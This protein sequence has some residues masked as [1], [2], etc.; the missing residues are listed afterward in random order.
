VRAALWRAGKLAWL[1]H[2]AQRG[3]RDHFLRSTALKFVFCCSRRWGKSWLLCVLAL[4]CALGGERRQI[5][6]AASTAKDVR[7]IIRPI[8]RELVQ[9]CPE[10][11]RPEWNSAEGAWT[12]HNGSQIHIAGV[13]NGNADSLRGTSAHLAIVDEAGFV[14]DLEYLVKSVLM[15]QLLTTDGRMI[16]SSTPATTPGHAFA[17][18]CQEA[19][20]A[21]AYARQTIYDAPHITDAKI[22]LYVA[23]SGGAQ[24]STWRR[25]YLA[26]HVTDETRA[27]IPEW[28]AHEHVIVEAR[29][30]PEYVYTWVAA[31]QGYYDLTVVGFW[32]YD[33]RAAL[34]V[35]EDELVFLRT[36]SDIIASAVRAKEI[37]IWRDVKPS[38]VP[39]Q[40]VVDAPAQV[41]A[42]MN[43]FH[44]VNDP[45]RPESVWSLVRKDDA[46]AALNEVR[47]RVANHRIRIHPRCV[48]T[49]SHLRHAVWNKARTQYERSADHGHFDGV[50][51]VKYAVRT[52]Q[53]SMNPWPA[54]D[55]A[56]KPDTHWISPHLQRRD[57]KLAGALLGRR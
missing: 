53:P 25:E 48:T 41:I 9:S 21:G 13:D 24:S 5:R 54:V 43:R 46:E 4:E 31:D 26:E 47:I 16:I 10:S 57:Q 44:Q 35:Q 38:S 42:D 49:I 56:A 6:Y 27:V 23:E 1:L 19:E 14:D 22:E 50:D 51:Q 7:K 37:A 28:A 39:Q 45:S 33:F 15:P 12:F 30:R 17:A 29:E 32:Y 55:P 52:V 3:V 34:T 18:Y 36:T 11:L 20:A 2:R 40:R 8:M